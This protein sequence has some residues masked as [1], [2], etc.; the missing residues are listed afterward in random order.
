MNLEV[1]SF[2]GFSGFQVSH[3]LKIGG[4]LFFYRSK[5]MVANPGK[6]VKIFNRYQKIIGIYVNFP[7]YRYDEICENFNEHEIPSFLLRLNLK[8]SK[9][10]KL[11]LFEILPQVVSSEQ[12][13][14][15]NPMVAAGM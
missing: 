13:A 1:Q 6:V 15:R 14:V 12:F 2:I 10:E 8:S 3:D 11:Q 7:Y 4:L 9:S 5:A